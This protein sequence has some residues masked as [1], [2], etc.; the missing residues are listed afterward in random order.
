MLKADE[1]HVVPLDDL[2]EHELDGACWCKPVE[3]VEHPGLWTHHALDGRE[4]YEEGRL[5]PH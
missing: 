5:R 4:N 2:R 1:L 3:D